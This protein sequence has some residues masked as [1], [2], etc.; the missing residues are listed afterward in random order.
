MRLILIALMF[1]VRTPFYIDMKPTEKDFSGC[2][3]YFPVVGILLGILVSAVFYIVSLLGKDIASLIALTVYV[4]V[5]LGFHL[6]GLA[7]CV[8]GL[9]SGTR[10]KD[11]VSI[12]KDSR[13][14]TFSVISIFLA[15]VFYIKLVSY[16]DYRV[17]FTFPIA[18][19]YSMTIMAVL[20]RPARKEGLGYMFCNK[21]GIREFIISTIITIAAGLFA[22]GVRFIFPAICAV[23]FA[24]IFIRSISSR[25]GGIN[26]DALGA[27]L[28]LSEITYLLVS[29]AQAVIL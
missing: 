29:Y 21:A 11:F 9:A 4:Y 2:T 3:A 26:G 22:M 13:V 6:D 20:F 23:I 10:G 16:V 28:V 5:A 14:G 1:L 27:S 12:M 18:G 24:L 15:S 7:D 25:M 17:L 8:D 19:R